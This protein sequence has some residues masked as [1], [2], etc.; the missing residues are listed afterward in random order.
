MFNSYVE[1]P[2]GSFVEFEENDRLTDVLLL[3]SH[4][5]GLLNVERIKHS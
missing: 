4:F 2:E 1:L 3:V 5:L